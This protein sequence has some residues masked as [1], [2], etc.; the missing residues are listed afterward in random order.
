M[1]TPA[2]MPGIGIGDGIGVGVGI[3]IG[4]G[5]G[6]GIGIGIG[7]VRGQMRQSVQLAHPGDAILGAS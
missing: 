5:V 6:V 4:I 1:P 7:V 3:G 2:L